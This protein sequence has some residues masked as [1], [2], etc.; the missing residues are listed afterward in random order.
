MPGIVV[1]TA[2]R[3]G[4]TNPQTAATATMFVA[5]ITTRGPD[6]TSHLV[7]SLSDFEDI[8]GGYTSD[9]Y[10]HQTVK[11]FFE[12]GGA[13]AYVSRAVEAAADEADCS[14]LSSG[15]E[16]VNL[17]ASGV[18]T[19]AN[20]SGSNGLSASVG[21]VVAATSFKLQ[22]RL[23]GALVWTSATHTSVADLIE[24]INNDS[25]VAL[26]VTA[27]AGA[28]TGLPTAGS[29]NFSGGTNGNS[30]SDAE[31]GNALDA[32]TSNLGPGAVCVP[33]HYGSTLRTD[34]IEHAAGNNRIAIMSF[35]KDD[36]YEDAISDV[37]SYSGADNAEFAGFFFPWIKVPNGSLTMVTPPEGYVCGARA[38]VHNQF[39][40]WNPYAGERTEATYVSG[41]YQSLS[42]T[43]AD[44]L[45]AGF[46]NPIRVINGTVRVY[47]ARSASDDTA[48]YRFI[49]A[50]EVLNQITYEAESELENLLFLPI[51]GRKSTFARVQATLVAI[52]D[53]IRI[54]GGLYEAFDANGRQ[55]DYGYTVQVNDANNPL[56]QLST[57]VIKAKIGARVSS[58]GDTIE[59]EITKSNLTATLV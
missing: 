46:V 41:V 29:A 42:K 58:I 13:R 31:L 8:Y 55:I 56:T 3:T 17:L 27:T 25:A 34:L 59:V 4:P 1:T 43:A 49:M 51:D 6:G 54:G 5:G 38:K 14:I 23:D 12:E 48:N 26:Y 2:V 37:A 33:G 32:F 45:D 9:G 35:D 15:T 52:M 57:G 53:R 16:C 28:S 39:G 24:E 7:T 44:A 21:Y 19:W 18:G 40:A 47:G 11:T 20:T 10:V 22:L 30:P 36:T 50:R